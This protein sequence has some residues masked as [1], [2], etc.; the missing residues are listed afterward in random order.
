M[1]GVARAAWRTWLGV[2]PGRR[3]HILAGHV[4]DQGI[5]PRQR[6]RDMANVGAA[7]Q[8]RD[9]DHHDIAH[10]AVADPGCDTGQGGSVSTSAPTPGAPVATGS[11]LEP[12]LGGPVQPVPRTRRCDR[13]YFIYNERYSLRR[14]ALASFNNATDV[15]YRLHDRALQRVSG[16]GAR[17]GLSVVCGYPR[18]SNRLWLLHVRAMSGDRVRHRWLLSK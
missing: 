8:G 18:R 14:A 15:P 4:G 12:S 13:L 9:L 3:Q 5:D 2:G 11:C 6:D 1:A 10:G 17:M 16:S 7:T